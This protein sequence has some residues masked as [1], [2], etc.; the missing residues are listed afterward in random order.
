MYEASS[1]CINGSLFCSAALQSRLPASAWHFSV[2]FH[3]HSLSSST[4]TGRFFLHGRRWALEGCF[5]SPIF[6]SPHTHSLS[7]FF[8]SSS[9]CSPLCSVYVESELHMKS[10]VRR[11]HKQHTWWGPNDAE[12]SRMQ[13]LCT[14][15][16]GSSVCCAMRTSIS[17]H[18]VHNAWLIISF[19]FDPCFSLS[20]SLHLSVYVW[21]I[22]CSARISLHS[23]TK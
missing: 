1:P 19:C 23:S 4:S 6:A 11:L 3:H 21:C 8:S 17:L 2:C 18:S 13:Y 16:K 5:L 9:L 14:S 20:L 10:E 12:A 15:E 7:T 22:E